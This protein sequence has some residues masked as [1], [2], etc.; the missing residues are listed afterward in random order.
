MNW[1]G[2]R[3]RVFFGKN[4]TVRGKP[5]KGAYDKYRNIVLLSGGDKFSFDDKI[6][7]DLGCGPMGALPFFPETSIKIGI[8]NLAFSYNQVFEVKEKRIYDPKKG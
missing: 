5:C 8:D 3:A 7:I 2:G 6:I 1:I 4:C